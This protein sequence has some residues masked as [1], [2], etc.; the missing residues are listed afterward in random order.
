M[1]AEDARVCLDDDVNT[2]RASHA[3]TRMQRFNAR[4]A[5]ARHNTEYMPLRRDR[6]CLPQRVFAYMR[7]DITR[8]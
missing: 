8:Y 6:R 1:R 4:F 7:Y 2:A 5:A 3:N